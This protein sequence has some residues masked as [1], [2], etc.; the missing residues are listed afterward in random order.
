MPMPWN[1]ARSAQRARR[2]SLRVHH[3]APHHLAPH[4][5]A[6][7]RGALAM[8]CLLLLSACGAAPSG[9]RFL[10]VY[11]RSDLAESEL[12]EATLE[13][14]LLLATAETERESVAASGLDQGALRSDAGAFVVRFE[15]PPPGQALVTLRISTPDGQVYEGERLAVIAGDVVVTQARV[16]VTRDEIQ[17]DPSQIGTASDPCLAPCSLGTCEERRCFIARSADWFPGCE[18]DTDRD[19]ADGDAG[20]CSRGECRG[21]VCQPRTEDSLCPPGRSCAEV[22][23]VYACERLSCRGLAE[24]TP[25]PGRAVDDPCDPPEFCDGT[26][27][28][29][30]RDDAIP[31]G[32]ACTG[33]ARGFCRRL[34]PTVPGTCH[35]GACTCDAECRPGER[36]DGELDASEACFEGRRDCGT[37]GWPCVRG[38]LREDGA[39]CGDPSECAE[40]PRCLDGTCVPGEARD[41]ACV[42]APGTGGECTLAECGPDGLCGVPV[43]ASTSC[44]TSTSP[45]C[46]RNE[47]DGAG[48]C[49]LT[50]DGTDARCG[51]RGGCERRSCVTSVSTIG[52][53]MTTGLDDAACR[54]TRAC[55]VGQCVAGVGCTFPAAPDGTRCP[56]SG[57]PGAE[58]TCTS[59]TCVCLLPTK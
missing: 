51:G 21:H 48:T 54:P 1:R 9:P 12:Q 40:A 36:C 14:E 52:E 38:A 27:D 6:L 58:G 29:C 23:G 19:C 33:S 25:C 20:E 47:C 16:L 10:E 26:S 43:T 44:G 4:H 28:E 42:L 2:A 37:E 3:L 57:S 17:C 22:A 53:C 56:C 30:P 15:D 55:Q 49:A 11:I 5:P 59:G 45:L 18:C 32:G 24:G 41:G 8:T 7:H 31:P 39:P 46:T 50:Y 13:L 34:E 35:G